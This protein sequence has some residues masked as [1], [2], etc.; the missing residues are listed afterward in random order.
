MSGLFSLVRER[1]KKLSDL[2]RAS[3]LCK[4]SVRDKNVFYIKSPAK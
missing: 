4:M 1:Y 3:E 2:I